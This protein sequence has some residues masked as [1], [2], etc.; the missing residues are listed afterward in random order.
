MSLEMTLDA[1]IF[2]DLSKDAYFG[3]NEPRAQLNDP[4]ELPTP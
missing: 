4:Q 3:R 2:G 1:D